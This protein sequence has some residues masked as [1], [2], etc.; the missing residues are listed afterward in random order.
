MANLTSS[1]IAK[2]FSEKPLSQPFISRGSLSV[3]R[4]PAEKFS[5]EQYSEHVITLFN[6][7]DD[8]ARIVYEFK[9]D[10]QF[11][12]EPVTTIDEMFFYGDNLDEA[13]QKLKFEAEA[14]DALVLFD[15]YKFPEENENR[16]QLNE[17]N[18]VI[19][20][21]PTLVTLTEM[22]LEIS[23]K[24]GMFMRSYFSYRLKSL[25][26]GCKINTGAEKK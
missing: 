3:C 21:Q 13:K 2:L 5:P 6:D 17:L 10:K 8:L 25:E 7:K 1:G 22:Y 14:L 4:Y 15:S 12:L 23:A 26:K 9:H 20:L 24:T 11:L 18:M 16:M 19:K